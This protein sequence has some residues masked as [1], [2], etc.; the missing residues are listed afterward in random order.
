LWQTL[1][2]DN[3]AEAYRAMWSLADAP[4]QTVVWVREHL[5][6]IAP[7]ERRRL[8][9]LIAELDSDTFSTRSQ[10]SEELEHLGELAV[11]A[12]RDALAAKPSLECRQHCEDLLA[13]LTVLA[14]SRLRGVRAVEVIEHIGTAEAHGLLEKWSQGAPAARQ[15]QEARAALERLSRRR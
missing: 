14:S 6:P 2:G 5:P 11:P 1:A 13:K 9:R 3:A 8:E 10:A 7:V 4:S 12:L 15:T